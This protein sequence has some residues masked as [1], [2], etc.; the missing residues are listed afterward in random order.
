MTD[1][2]LLP[3]GDLQLK[4]FWRVQLRGAPLTSALW[5]NPAGADELRSRFSGT[6]RLDRAAGPGWIAV[7]DVAMAFD[8]LSSQGIIKA[9]ES[10]WRG[11]G[12][13]TDI[14]NGAPRAVDSYLKWLESEFASYTISHRRHYGAVRRWPGSTFW[15]RRSG[16]GMTTPRSGMPG[17]L[18][19]PSDA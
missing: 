14:L 10:G 11:A 9:L 2:D 3:R 19:S 8:P 18:T 17:M 5:R 15:N 12:A 1:A 13:V 4:S 7:G 16:L 6:V